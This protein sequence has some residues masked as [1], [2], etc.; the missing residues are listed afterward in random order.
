MSDSARDAIYASG[1]FNLNGRQLSFAFPDL[2]TSR[3][4]LS[5]LGQSLPIGDVRVASAFTG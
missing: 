5:V 4:S 2:A 1:L 3:E